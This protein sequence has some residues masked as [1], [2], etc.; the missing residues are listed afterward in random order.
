M[1]YICTVLSLIEI[2]NPRLIGPKKD[3]I[4]NGR[5]KNVPNKQHVF[6]AITSNICVV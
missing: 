4:N 1:Q 6:Y 5:I 3:A 2:D